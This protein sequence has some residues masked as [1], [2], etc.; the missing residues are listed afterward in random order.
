MFIATVTN[1]DHTLVY[2][3]THTSKEDAITDLKSA[4]VT[5]SQA[6]EDEEV[7]ETWDDVLMIT[8]GS[9]EYYGQVI[10]ANTLP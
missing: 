7:K 1:E 6:D 10:K 5:I 3:S 2:A 9:S 8:S 4:L